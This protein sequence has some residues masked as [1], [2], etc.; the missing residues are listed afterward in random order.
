VSEF[1]RTK[2]G[3]KYGKSEIRCACSDKRY[4]TLTINTPK[5]DGDIQ[6]TFT[7][8]GNVYIY[9]QHKELLTIKKR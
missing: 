8:S 5:T 6:I 4:G 2:Y 7:P 9:H 3:I 1:T